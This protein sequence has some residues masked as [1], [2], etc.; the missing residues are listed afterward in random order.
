VYESADRELTTDELEHVSGG[1]AK[2]T[3][4]VSPEY[5]RT[6]TIATT[7]NLS[8]VSGSASGGTSV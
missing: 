3:I 8:G 1:S 4:K 2:M 5:T 7:L 6:Q